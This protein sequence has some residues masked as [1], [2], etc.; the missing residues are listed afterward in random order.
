M[1]LFLIAFP[2]D[3]GTSKL[4]A[5]RVLRAGCSTREMYRAAPAK[6]AELAKVAA[7]SMKRPPASRSLNVGQRMQEPGLG[8]RG[9]WKVE[10]Q[11]SIDPDNACTCPH[12]IL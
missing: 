2:L 8:E 10:A 12:V 9:K 3:F 7:S 1:A 4:D 6:R 5:A 11:P